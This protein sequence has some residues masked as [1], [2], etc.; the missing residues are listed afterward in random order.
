MKINLD[1]LADEIWG[2]PIINKPQKIQVAKQMA[3]RLKNGDVVGI[4]GGSTSFLTL[5]ALVDRRDKE[6][7]T[8][9]AIPASL[10]IE[11]VCE[12]LKVPVV[13]LKK[14][15]PD[16]CFD[17]ADEVDPE[18]NMIKGRGGAM[19]REKS[20]IKACK[21]V[22][23]VVD[24]SKL[25]RSLGQNFPV[26]VE[27][28]TSA[29]FKALNSLEKLDKVTEVKLRQTIGQDGPVITDNSNIIFDVHFSQI[30]LDMEAKINN[31]AGVVDNGLFI[32]YQPQI[33]ISKI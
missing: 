23:I 6:G 21:E 25:V 29:F 3:K 1:G 32:G 11:F 18:G 2:R 22:Y 9:S 8:F 26:P 4:G 14:R 20:L 10:V 5:K 33:V 28:R 31:L 17:G 27:V 15:K 7:I 24:K 16:W 13:T 12:L 30:G 19:V